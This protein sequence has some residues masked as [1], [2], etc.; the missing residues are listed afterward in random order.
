MI[1]GKSNDPVLIKRIPVKVW[2][3]RSE[4]EEAVRLRY[5][6][7]EKP[8]LE[9]LIEIYKDKG[10]LPVAEEVEDDNNELDPQALADAAM[11]GEETD[12]VTPINEKKVIKQFIPDLPKEKLFSG[13]LLL[14][15]LYMEGM[16]F[17]CEREFTQGQSIVVDIQ[18]PNRIILNGIV[19]YSRTFNMKSRIISNASLPYRTGIK[20]TFLKEGERTLLRNFIKSFEPEVAQEAP[21]S[22]NATPASP[23]GG[24]DDDELDIFDDL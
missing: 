23:A 24:D 12:N 16:Y 3:L 1:H 4:V 7:G 10:E 2:T 22:V 15:E 14:S 9:D 5:K 17:F 8:D 18:I 11:N 20:F 13:N 21:K 6:E 19:V